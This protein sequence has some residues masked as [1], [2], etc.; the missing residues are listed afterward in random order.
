MGVIDRTGL[1]DA[2][3]SQ[4]VPLNTKKT[5]V[6]YCSACHEEH[7]IACFYHFRGGWMGCILNKGSRQKAMAKIKGGP[8]AK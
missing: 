8:K 4:T 3:W 1:T 2:D 7:D 6:R 5:H